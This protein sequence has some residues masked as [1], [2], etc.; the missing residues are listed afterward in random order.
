MKI[1][2]IQNSDGEAHKDESNWLQDRMKCESAESLKA[3]YED[4]LN[5]HETGLLRENSLLRSIRREYSE[6]LFS[7]HCTIELE[8]IIKALLLEIARRWV[9]T[10]F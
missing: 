4:V 3:M 9:L 2:N 1:M 5:F 6:E 8:T 7:N 10:A